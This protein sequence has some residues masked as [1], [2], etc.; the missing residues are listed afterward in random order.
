MPCTALSCKQC[1][2]PALSGGRCSS[3]H[4]RLGLGV[5]GLDEHMVSPMEL[6]A[7]LQGGRYNGGGCKPVILSKCALTSV[8]I[9]LQTLTHLLYARFLCHHGD[10]VRANGTSL[11]SEAY[12]IPSDT[13]LYEW[14]HTSM[15]MRS[16]R[17]ASRVPGELW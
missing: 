6:L 9:C 2:S 11:I 12:C 13:R 4:L 7:S 14:R 8:L 15:Y 1:P 3:D 16:G 5:Q 17:P 10:A